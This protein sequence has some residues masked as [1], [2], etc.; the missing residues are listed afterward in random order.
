MAGG[1]DAKKAEAISELRE[2][3]LVI[4]GT[5]PQLNDVV[6]ESK[7]HWSNYS[8]SKKKTEKLIQTY[9]LKAKL[10]P[11]EGPV[12][13]HF[14]WITKDYK[15]DADNIAFAKKY[16][17]DALCSMKILKKDGRD[18]VK[19]WIDEFPDKDPNNPRV[20]VIIYKVSEEDGEDGE[21][22]GE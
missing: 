2:Q 1:D 7:G 12:W 17:I 19:G 5:L 21:E 16:I 20:E 3:V 18:T 22:E 13:F 8:E 14:S 9:I 10:K 4:P 15:C 6:R 11:I